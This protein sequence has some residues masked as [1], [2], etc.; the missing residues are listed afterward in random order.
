MMSNIYNNLTPSQKIRYDISIDSLC[1]S[2]YFK[3]KSV[4][5]NLILNIQSNNLYGIENN[6][7][8]IKNFIYNEAIY[9]I[10]QFQTAKDTLIKHYSLLDTNSTSAF[11]INNLGNNTPTLATL[12]N[13]FPEIFNSQTSIGVKDCVTT[14]YAVAAA[15]TVALV[16]TT[17]G[18]AIN[19]VVAVNIVLETN[20]VIHSKGKIFS[21]D[22]LAYSWTTEIAEISQFF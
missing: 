16:A 5:H 7:I 17:A 6:L 10:N 20:V 19:A 11:I 3:N 9:N 13:Q 22:M 14:A 8:L 1:S 2:V 18:V 15:V 4:F 12:Q 21:S